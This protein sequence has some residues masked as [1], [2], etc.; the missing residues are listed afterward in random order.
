[1]NKYIDIII[2]QNTTQFTNFCVYS[3]GF[4][5]LHSPVETAAGWGVLCFVFCVLTGNYVIILN[6]ET[7]KV[8]LEKLLRLQMK[9]MYIVCVCVCVCVQRNARYLTEKPPPLP[10]SG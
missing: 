3:S 6:N 7:Y 1:M 8:G 5:L 2:S 9:N 10:V 4:L